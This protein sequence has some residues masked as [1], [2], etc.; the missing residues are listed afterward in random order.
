MVAIKN[1]DP[2]R[3]QAKR[4]NAMQ[5]HRI[6][7]E[8]TES[9]LDTC[10]RIPHLLGFVGITKSSRNCNI[11]SPPNSINSKPPQKLPTTSNQTLRLKPQTHDKIKT[12]AQE[13]N[14]TPAQ[15]YKWFIDSSL[16]I[17]EDDDDSPTLPPTLA[18]IRGMKN[19]PQRMK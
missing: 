16:A 6:A 5:S 8:K 15:V 7:S 4:F 18:L 1:L 9:V 3:C 11:P 19:K 12:I 10:A 17:I 14:T 13:L 2:H